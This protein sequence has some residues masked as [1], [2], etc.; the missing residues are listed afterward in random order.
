MRG[1]GSPT[2]MSTTRLPPK[3][4]SSSTSPCGLGA[5]L[6]DDRRAGA[7]RVRPEQRRAPRR[8]PRRRRRRP[9]GPRWRRR[10]GRCRGSRDV[11]DDLRRAPA[12]A[13][14]SSADGDVRPPGRARSARS[15]DRRA[16]GRA[17]SE[18][19][20][21]R[22][23]RLRE[24]EHARGV[25][26]EVDLELQLAAGDHHGHAVVAD[27]AGDEH[28]VARPRRARGRARRLGATTPIPAV[29]T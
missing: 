20:A 1:S 14:S 9:A 18:A 28:A 23:Q 19:P 17:C 6:A 7:E 26:L 29:V 27:R 22:E 24:L 11:P 2:S 21:E 13:L 8:T 25:A 10:A 4:V 16:S 12:S 15:R 5:H 3:L